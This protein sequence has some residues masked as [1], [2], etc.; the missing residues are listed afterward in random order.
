MKATS[1]DDLA[2]MAQYLAGLQ[3]EQYLNQG[4]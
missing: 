2:A 3:I 4:R 1:T